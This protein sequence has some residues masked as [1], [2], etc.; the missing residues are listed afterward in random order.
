MQVVAYS[1]LTVLFYKINIKHYIF[2]HIWE[3]CQAKPSQTTQSDPYY[4]TLKIVQTTGK[5]LP[6]ILA[7]K[8]FFIELEQPTAMNEKL[9]AQQVPHMNEKIELMALRCTKLSS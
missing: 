9:A 4:K 1:T 8:N 7:T 5:M 6:R 3:P 2:T